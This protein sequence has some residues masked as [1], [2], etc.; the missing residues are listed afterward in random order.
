MKKNR[1]L[2]LT[3]V[4]PN[5]LPPVHAVAQ[6]FRDEG[7]F[8]DILC[9]DNTMEDDFHPGKNINVHPIGEYHNKKLSQRIYLKLRFNRTAN[10]FV[11]PETAAVISF[12]SYSYLVALKF[13]KKLSVYHI[14]LEI[15]DSNLKSFINS[16]LNTYYHFRAIKSM[17]KAT[18]V[19]TPSIQR[20]AWLAGR[21][22]TK[23]LP[24][25]IHNTSYLPSEP[26][27]QD[28]KEIY[29]SI[30]PAHFKNK[31]VLLY[32]G[33]VN[34]TLCIQEFIEGFRLVKEE[35]YVVITGMKDNE[36]CTNIIKT[37]N[38][39]K[40][41]ER[42]L[43]LPYVPREHMIALQSCANIGIL[44]FRQDDERI[45][46]R[47][48][49]PN[50]AGEY[51]FR[52]LLLLGNDVYYL[53]QFEAEGLAVLSPDLSPQEISKAIS[54]ALDK[55]ENSR[56]LSTKFVQRKFNMKVQLKPVTDH[57]KGLNVV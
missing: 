31:K 28:Y 3:H 12:C 10:K 2:L 22:R 39:A 8:I 18:M 20:S 35:C 55:V 56:D 25:T 32:T 51:L 19:A 15:P 6:V 29:E 38:E 23:F 37:I 49:A 24:Y 11:T 45:A 47:M 48:H 30:V 7:Y 26:Q 46:T 34:S 57:L 16:P 53:R 1:L 50:K 43:L 41:A 14:A 9:F 40:M 33:N 54:S 44:F 5:W 42:F 4:H 36:Y 52:G 21:A 13:R 27:Q 17:S